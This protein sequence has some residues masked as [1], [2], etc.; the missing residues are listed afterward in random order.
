MKPTLYSGDA[1]FAEAFKIRDYVV[2]E[3]IGASED[4]W[5]ENLLTMVP[6][7]LFVPLSPDPIR[8]QDGFMYYA[9]GIPPVNNPLKKKYSVIEFDELARASQEGCGVLFYTGLNDSGEPFLRLTMGDMLCYLEHQTLVGVPS[10]LE[11]HPASNH[12]LAELEI[13]PVDDEILPPLAREILIG[14]FEHI[15]FPDIGVTTMIDK[16]LAPHRALI[17]NILPEEVEPDMTE[18]ILYRVKFFL[19]PLRRVHLNE[20]LIPDDDFTPLYNE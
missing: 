18:Q 4:E 1:V 16:G 13:I 3:D 10:E 14:F 2:A 12:E 15:G 8:G 19:K 7:A 20:F 17:L 11:E 9:V 5:Y 6:K